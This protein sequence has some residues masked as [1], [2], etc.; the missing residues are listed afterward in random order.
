MVGSAPFGLRDAIR[1]L[2]E[3]QPAERIHLFLAVPGALAL[4]L[5]HR[6]NALR[7]TVVY[8]HLGAGAGYASTLMIP[9]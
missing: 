7:P 5:G 4:L 1:D 9:A 3:Q 2:L 8:E 6:W